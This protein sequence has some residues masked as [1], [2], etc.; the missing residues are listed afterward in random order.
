MFKLGTFGIIFDKQGQV[1]LCHRRDYDL[2]NLPGGGVEAGEAPW[3]GV[4]REVKEEV[5]LNVKVKRISG[6]YFKPDQNEVAFSFVCEVI[7]GEPTLS[8]EAD[9]IKYFVTSAL[10]KNISQKQVERIRDA[11]QN[12]VETIYKIQKGPRTIELMKKGLL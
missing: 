6:V 3:D 12:L 10:P 1:L 2:W 5:G 9:E 11:E 8:A 4:I 7:S